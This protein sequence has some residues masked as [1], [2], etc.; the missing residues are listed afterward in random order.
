[1]TPLRR[2]LLPL[3]LLAA[4]A[5][6][7][8]FTFRRP[9]VVFR[10]VELGSLDSSGAALEASFD[11]TNPNRYRIGVRRLT[12]RV[13]VNGRDAGGGASDQETVLEGKA[14][15]LVKLPMTLDW[16]KVRSA[17]LDFLFSG[18]IDYAVEG[19]ITFSTPIGVFERPYRHAGRWS[20]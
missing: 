6:A 16:S 11:V 10:G 13:S 18:S 2:V 12:Y 20:R 4:V 7:G 17:G 5:G 19:E 14:T 3:V 1:V 8:C 9:E 15:T